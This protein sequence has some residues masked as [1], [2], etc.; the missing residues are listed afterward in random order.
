M[1]LSIQPRE[2][3]YDLQRSQN[4]V[5]LQ[6][7]RNAVPPYAHAYIQFMSPA[8]KWCLPHDG[9]FMWTIMVTNHSIGSYYFV[10]VHKAYSAGK[11]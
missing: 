5:S 2:F 6:Q 11:K 1:G 3:G 10:L 7:L 8:N 4:A 9:T